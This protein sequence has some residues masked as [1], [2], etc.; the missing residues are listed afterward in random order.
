MTMSGAIA[1]GSS[2]WPCSCPHEQMKIFFT[3]AY[4]G[5]SEY[6][7][8]Y[9][10]VVKTLR[11]LGT[12]VISLEVQKHEDL[13]GKT[14]IKGL[15]ENELHYSYIKKGVKISSA[16][17]I[18]ASVDSF[19]MGF[20][21]ALALVYNKPVLCLSM[22]KDFSD[23]I[24]HKDFYATR[25]E[26]EAELVKTVRTF[27]AN[28]KRKHSSIRFN[29]YFTPE[30]VNFLKWFSKKS[31]K[32]VSEVVRELVQKEMEGSDEYGAYGV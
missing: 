15:S 4:S 8:M 16:V 23:N 32:T 22:T 11:E 18:E 10:A 14:V 30:Q 21:S 19:R 1:S 2:R 31:G 28:V 24:R 25:Y 12:E 27:I 13:L 29:G 3:A 26:S 9:N 7:K 20:E 6:Q 17:V 5:K